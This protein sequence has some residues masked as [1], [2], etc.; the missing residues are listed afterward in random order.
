MNTSHDTFLQFMEKHRV[1]EKN[2]PFNIVGMGDY[3][4]K[5]CIEEAEQN[6]FF[7]YYT[8]EVFQRKNPVSLIEMHKPYGPLVCDLDFKFH[9]LSETHIYSN[10]FIQEFL[11]RWM[12]IIERYID[13]GHEQQRMAFVMEKQHASSSTKDGLHIMFP[14]IITEP[15]IQYIMREELIEEMRSLVEFLHGTIDNP[16]EDVL[17]SSVIYRNG[18]MMYGSCKPDKEPYLLTGIWDVSKY[19][20]RS[21]TIEEKKDFYFNHR[22]LVE[23]LSIQKPSIGDLSD[24]TEFGKSYIE[25]YKKEQKKTIVKTTTDPNKT[26]CDDLNFV[27][28]LVDLLD[29]QRAE[30]YQQWIEV[31]WCLYNIDFRLKEKWIE[32]SEKSDQYRESASMECEKEWN[33]MKPH[34]LSH[35]TLHMWVKQDNPVHYHQLI[36][37]SLEYEIR[38]CCINLS[39]VNTLDKN[40]KKKAS[41]DDVSFYIVKVIRKLYSYHFVCSSYSHKIWWEYRNHRW[42]LSDKGVSLRQMIAEDVYDIFNKMSM[43]YHSFHAKTDDGVAKE[44]YLK[45]ALNSHNI[46]EKLRNI[47]FRNTLLDEAAEQFYW[48]SE[49]DENKQKNFE[50]ILDSNLYLI[51]MK[52]GVFDLQTFTMRQGRCEDF[53]SMTTMNEYIDY[54]WE[55]PT[56][57][58]IMGFI[59]Q[60]IP[61]KEVRDYVLTLLGSF[62]DGNT[63][64]EKFHIWVGSGGNGK[65]KLIELFQLSMGEYC[66][67]LPVTVITQQRPAS[68]AA[69]PELARLKGKRFV[70][71]QEPNEKEK[72]QVGRMKELTGGDTIYA[73]SLHKEPI[74][75]KP[76]FKMILACNH[77]PRV[78]PDDGGTWRRIRVVRFNSKFVEHP[79]PED[80]EQFHQDLE[81]SKKLRSWKEGFFWILTQYYKWYK[82]GDESLGIA[83][84]IQE[85]HE[86]IDVTN[87]YRNRNDIMS[88]FLQEH[89]MEDSKSVLFLI[90]LY[91]RYISW[92]KINNFA[93]F[94]R[95]D[96]QETIEN[97]LGNICLKKKGWKGYSLRPIQ[98]DHS[99]TLDDF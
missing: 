18:W 53:V 79:D 26:I 32:F 89:I 29:P 39:P 27:C 75:Y 56:I 25:Y 34:G 46:A 7:N 97:R 66:G 22:R 69:S 36:R 76:Q 13:I 41:W 99:S 30:N 60:V 59:A 14:F 64:N 24:L 31:G 8:H 54:T 70:S 72:L 28:S 88:D 1:K 16:L 3:R 42:F 44:R 91:S 12:I 21:F 2:R 96:F 9:D 33:K 43:K 4:G 73:R 6:D 95:N 5:Y 47:K 81:L 51:G 37:Q 83:P 58:D 45:L 87:Q 80:P 77:L 63:G 49:D 40:S 55:S 84:G 38:Q 50:E 82:I 11:V 52:N 94:Q 57:Q 67:S 90:D 65:S 68:N 23:I 86:V 71:I 15:D 85:P 10:Q 48:N 61:N 98:T 19:Q 78:P 17:D 62:I 20:A 35:G 93:A 92:C 74:E